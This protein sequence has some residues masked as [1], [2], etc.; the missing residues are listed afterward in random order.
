MGKSAC[1]RPV[2]GFPTLHGWCVT[3]I[4]YYASSVAWSDIQA[5]AAIADL[6][7]FRLGQSPFSHSF[8]NA[9]LRCPVRIFYPDI[10]GCVAWAEIVVLVD[11]TVIHARVRVTILRT[12]PCLTHSIL[13][14]RQSSFHHIELA[15][16]NPLV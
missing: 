1:L 12:R 7:A 5:L 2:R 16:R 13:G 10:S 3:P 4:D 11:P 6:S 8:R 9:R 15:L 14:F